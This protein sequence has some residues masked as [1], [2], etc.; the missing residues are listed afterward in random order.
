MFQGVSALPACSMEGKRSLTLAPLA[1]ASK[2]RTSLRL[3]S[4]FYT[5]KAKGLK[6]GLPICK[7][8]VEAHGGTVEVKT[9][10]GSG[11]TFIVALPLFEGSRPEVS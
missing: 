5:T 11:T 1:E 6:L 10:K 8:L 2:K 7:K 9:R 4:G 3:F